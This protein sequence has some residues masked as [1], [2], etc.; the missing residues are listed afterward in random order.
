MLGSAF[1]EQNTAFREAVQI[2]RV[3]HLFAVSAHGVAP[4]LVRQ[5]Q[6]Y[7]RTSSAYRGRAWTA[8]GEGAVQKFPARDWIHVSSRSVAS[9]SGSSPG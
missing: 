4:V 1:R 6:Q 9:G 3:D 8:H 7:I 2:L 5:D